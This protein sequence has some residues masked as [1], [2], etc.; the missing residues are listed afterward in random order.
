MR[1]NE[2]SQETKLPSIS[3]AL[4]ERGSGRCVL[5]QTPFKNNFKRL[6]NTTR[7]LIASAI[8]V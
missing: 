4:S 7:N 2:S 5:K 8:A 6:A 1:R 3:C